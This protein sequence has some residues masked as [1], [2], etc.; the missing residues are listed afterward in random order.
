MWTQKPYTIDDLVAEIRT[1]QMFSYSRF[2]D[3]EWSA[4]LGHPGA[5]CDLCE[6]FPEL[7]AALRRAMT[8]RLPYRRA[9]AA[10]EDHPL[11]SEFGRWMESKGLASREWYPTELFARGA[12][13]YAL[14]GKRVP[15]LDMLLSPPNP[16]LSHVV[17]GPRYVLES[18]V[19]PMDRF[20]EVPIR[21]AYRD[22]ERIEVEI[23]RCVT[24]LPKPAIVSIS[25]GMASNVIVE[26]LYDGL[27][28]RALLI[29]VGALWEP[30][31]ERATRPWHKHVIEALR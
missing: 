4:M 22:L 12:L 13:E 21:D 8:S 14:K 2:G 20:V 23:G 15:Y 9:L 11:P 27:H 29:D 25:A 28:D 17:V 26:D 16:F 19:V 6:Y 1:G 18:G 10:W 24:V 31:I 5:N 30:Y 7:G 3:G